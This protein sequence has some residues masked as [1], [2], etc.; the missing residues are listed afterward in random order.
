MS[1]RVVTDAEMEARLRRARAVERIWDTIAAITGDHGEMTGWDWA[2]VFHEVQGRFIAIELD[3][4]R[5]GETD[6]A[7]GG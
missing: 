6:P 3:R 7:A 2:W 4:E 5:T 1:R